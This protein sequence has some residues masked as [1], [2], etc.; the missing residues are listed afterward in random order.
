MTP[1]KLEERALWAFN[2]A[3]EAENI[4]KLMAILKL[5]VD[6]ERERCAK[7]AEEH[8]GIGLGVATRIAKKIRG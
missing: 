1:E 7:I 5:C 2:V 6:E 8:Q 4:N 3:H